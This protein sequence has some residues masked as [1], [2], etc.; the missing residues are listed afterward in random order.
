M[1]ELKDIFTLH[2]AFTDLTYE[3]TKQMIKTFHK[4]TEEN[5]KVLK[6]ITIRKMTAER[7]L[8]KTISK[9]QNKMAQNK[10]AQNNQ[11]LTIIQSRRKNEAERRVRFNNSTRRKSIQL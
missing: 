2:S 7:D 4:P 11:K 1:S 3:E 5:N 6:N 10:Q 8:F 9:F